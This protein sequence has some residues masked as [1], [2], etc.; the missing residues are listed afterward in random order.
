M[1]LPVRRPPPR[2]HLSSPHTKTSHAP[3]CTDKITPRPQNHTFHS[4]TTP[5]KPTKMSQTAPSSSPLSLPPSSLQE[6]VTPRASSPPTQISPGTSTGIDSP[7]TTQIATSASTS[8]IGTGVQAQPSEPTTSNMSRKRTQ[9]PSNKRSREDDNDED[10]P[11]PKKVASPPKAQVKGKGKAAAKKP[12]AKKLA[13]KKPAGPP[14]TS[15]R[16][17]RSRKAPERFEDLQGAKPVKAAP[18]KKTPAKSKV[19]D[20]VFITTNSA[21]RL[22][23]ADVYHMLLEP[24]AWT[25]LSAEQQISLLSMLP[26]DSTTTALIAKV[27]RGETEGTRPH[28]FNISNDCFRTDVAKFKEDLKN[29]HLAKTWQASAEQAIIERAAGDY[30]EWKAEESELWWGQKADA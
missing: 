1:S 28:A 18:A 25:C 2:S 13:T 27:K 9:Q 24:T 12:A 30:D 19:F 20:P 6:T 4:F 21:S 5:T 14:P 11:S 16:P 29:G 7:V 17:S 8:D 3:S 10:S 23:K 22:G 26:Q 15:T